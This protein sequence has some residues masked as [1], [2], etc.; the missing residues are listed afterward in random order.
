MEFILE[1]KG[2]SRRQALQRAGIT[3]CFMAGVRTFSPSHEAALLTAECV[4]FYLSV[5]VLSR[6]ALQGK[7]LQ[8]G[9]TEYPAWSVFAA[10]VHNFGTSFAILLVILMTRTIAELD[11]W[12]WMSWNAPDTQGAA[13]S[14]QR[15]DL[16]V[17][18]CG[19]AQE[20]KDSILLDVRARPE[21][22]GF[23]IHHAAT[24][25]G[26]LFSLNVPVG[27]GLVTLNAINAYLGSAAFNLCDMVPFLYPDRPALKQKVVVFYWLVMTSS[28]G[29]ACYVAV[30]FHHIAATEMRCHHVY[31]VLTALL[32]LL[33]Q[34]PVLMSI[35]E[36]C[37]GCAVKEA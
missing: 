12:L 3:A 36:N 35:Y 7:T 24:V 18:A 33:R 14:V 32:V 23:L 19:M 25:A 9:G 6:S 13:F 15:L 17:F 21:D 4:A 8:I 16:L 2:L 29:L 26:C 28:N 31:T 1:M 10:F 20:I 27:R 11:A 22:I 34:V 37:A 30:Q 5:C